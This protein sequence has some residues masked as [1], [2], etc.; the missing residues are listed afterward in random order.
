LRRAEI[1]EGSEA[2]RRATPELL[3]EIMTARGFEPDVQRQVSDF[4]GALI[5][6]RAETAANPTSRMTT[7]LNRFE[8]I[9]DAIA[10]LA[11]RNAEVEV[12][13]GR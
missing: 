4:V 13:P 3:V 11:E 8:A 1:I 5:E 6:A 7:D 10:G 9:V 2:L 12:S